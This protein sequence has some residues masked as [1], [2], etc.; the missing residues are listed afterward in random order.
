[1]NQAEAVRISI[2]VPFYDEQKNV[3]SLY[4]KITEAMDQ[5][6]EPYEMIFVDDGSKDDTY[7]VLQ[8]IYEHDRRVNLLRM[9]RNFGQTSALK[10]GFDHA[11]GE[12]VIS[13]DGD[14]QNDPD[15][16]P[17][18]LEKMKEGYDIVSGWRVHRAEA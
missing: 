13:M 9:R 7:R 15:E 5:V 12:I 2:V 11:R 6:G 3:S 1:M 10:A 4:V 18:F 17:R 8:E 16:I 14:L